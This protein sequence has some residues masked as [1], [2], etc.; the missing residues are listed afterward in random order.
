VDPHFEDICEHPSSDSFLVS[1]SFQEQYSTPDGASGNGEPHPNYLATGKA[2]TLTRTWS[3]SDSCLRSASQ[4]QIIYVT[5]TEAPTLRNIPEDVTSQCDEVPPPCIVTADDVCDKA[6]SVEYAQEIVPG[7]CDNRYTVYRTWTATDDS[8]NSVSHTQ[9]IEVV[10]NQAPEFIGAVGDPDSTVSVSCD[11][12]PIATAI[13][14]KDNCDESFNAVDVELDETLSGADDSS[15]NDYTIYRTWKATD[16][17]GNTATRTQTVHVSDTSPPEIE[18][19][20][21]DATYECDLVPPPCVA[22][23]TDNCDSGLFATMEA[24]TLTGTCEQEF[25]TIYT[26]TATD[27]SGNTASEAQTVY[28]QDTVAPHLVTTGIVDETL[29][30]SEI[31]TPTVTA[32]DDCGEVSVEYIESKISE[33]SDSEYTLRRSWT[34]TDDCGNT[35]NFVQTVKVV[36]TTPPTVTGKPCDADIGCHQDL[37]TANPV[38]TDDCCDATLTLTTDE[39]GRT[40]PFNYT[41]VRTWTAT[42]CAGNEETFQQHIVV[43]DDRGPILV[44]KP[45]DLFVSWGEEGE[46]ADVEVDHPCE[47]LDPDYTQSEITGTCHGEKTI[48]RTWSVTDSCGRTDSHTQ[49]ILVQDT[50]PPFILEPIPEDEEA[51]CLD[52]L[53]PPS[54]S[55]HDY[56][57]GPDMYATPATVT[58]E[59]SSTFQDPGTNCQYEISRTWTATDDCGNT[60]TT[61][62][63]VVV[64]DTS[65]PTFGTLDPMD[66]ICI[67]TD[68]SWQ[69][70]TVSD[71]CH[72]FTLSFVDTETPDTCSVLHSRKWTAVDD[73]GNEKSITDWVRAVYC[74]T[75]ELLNT[76]VNTT[77]ECGSP[78]PQPADVTS[79]LGGTPTYNQDVISTPG[80]HCEYTVLRTWT[81]SVPCYGT[82]QHVQEIVVSDNT[83]PTLVGVPDDEDQTCEYSPPVHNVD[84]TDDCSSTSVT[85]GYLYTPNDSPSDPQTHVFAWSATDQCGLTSEDVQTILVRDDEPP[86]FS[87]NY[88]QD[89]T[90]SCGDSTDD[91]T[92]CITPLQVSDN[93]GDNGLSLVF[94]DGSSGGTCLASSGSRTY[95]ATDAFG[96]TATGTVQWSITSDSGP[97]W[98]TVDGWE[99]E[100]FGECVAPYFQD[101][102]AQRDCTT[103][104]LDVTFS[105]EVVPDVNFLFKQK[106][107]WTAV[108]DCDRSIEKVQVVGAYDRSPPY[109]QSTPG[110]LT[111][112]AC[113]VVYTPPQLSWSDNCYDT[114]MTVDAEYSCTGSCPEICIATWSITDDAGLSNSHS[115]TVT[116]DD[117]SNPVLTYV[118]ETNS[119]LVSDCSAFTVIVEDFTNE[120]PCGRTDTYSIYTATDACSNSASEQTPTRTEYNVPTVTVENTPDDITSQCPVPAEDYA[121]TCSNGQ[122]PVLVSR[123]T[124]NNCPGLTNNTWTCTVTDGYDICHQD[125]YSQLIHVDDTIPPTIS[126]PADISCECG[127]EDDC[128]PGTATGEDNCDEEVDVDGS[129]VTVGWVTVA[130]WTATDTC[131]NTADAGSSTVTIIDTTPPVLNVIGDPD[132]TV[133]YPEEPVP[134]TVTCTD[135]CSATSMTPDTTESS[136]CPQH[137]A[138]T[139]TYS[140]V[141]ESGNQAVEVV[142]TTVVQDTTPPYFVGDLP[143]NTTVYWDEIPPKPELQA[144][145]TDDE[146]LSDSIVLS[147]QMIDI[148]SD[149]EYTLRRTWTVTDECGNVAVH[150]Q[151]ITVIPH[152]EY[153]F[154]VNTTVLCHSSIPP[155]ATITVGVNETVSYSSVFKPGSC[156]GQFEIHRTFVVLAADGYQQRA[157][158]TQ[159]VTVTDSAAPTWTSFPPDS[160]FE[161]DGSNDCVP[162]PPEPPTAED[163]CAFSTNPTIETSY[164]S[165]A[166]EMAALHPA[167][168]ASVSV[169]AVTGSPQTLND[170]VVYTWNA[171]DDCGNLLSSRSQTIHIHDTTA[172]AFDFP[173]G[174]TYNPSTTVPPSL[175]WTSDETL[176][177]CGELPEPTLEASDPCGDVTVTRTSQTNGYTCLNNYSL[178]FLF[179]A[180]DVNGNVALATKTY[181]VRDTTDPVFVSFPEDESAEC[182]LPVIVP[183]TAEDCGVSRSVGAPVIDHLVGENVNATIRTWT[184]H[185]ACGNSATQSQTITVTD[186][187]PPEILPTNLPEDVTEICVHNPAPDLEV[188][189]NCDVDPTVE[190]DE[191]VSSQTCESDYTIIR[192][193]TVSDEVDNQVTHTQTVTVQDPAPPSW[194]NPQP[195]PHVSASCMADLDLGLP[196]GQDECGT[197]TQTYSDAED[198]TCNG[199]AGAMVRTHTLDD[200]CHAPVTF[201]QSFSVPVPAGLLTHSPGVSV[202]FPDLSFSCPNDVTDAPEVTF[203][204]DCKEDRVVA[205]DETDTSSTNSCSYQIFRSWT[206]TDVCDVEYSEDQVVTV[207]HSYNPTLLVPAGGSVMCGM[208]TDPGEGSATDYCGN[209]LEVSKTVFVDNTGCQPVYTYTYTAVD[210]CGNTATE[211]VTVHVVDVEAPTLIGVPVDYTVTCDADVPELPTVADNCGS[212]TLTFSYEDIDEVCLHEFKRVYTWRAT[213][214]CGNAASRVTTI[215]VVNAG[216]PVWVNATLPLD[217]TSDGC[218]QLPDNSALLAVSACGDP[219]TAQPHRSTTGTVC[220]RTTVDTWTATDVCNDFITHSRTI[221]TADNTPPGLVIGDPMHLPCDNP[222]EPQ[223]PEVT[224]DCS[225]ATLTDKTSYVAPGS[226]GGVSTTVY[227]YEACNN[228]GACTTGQREVIRTDR[229]APTLGV[230][231]V[232]GT[233]ECKTEPSVPEPTADDNCD[234]DP[235]VSSAVVTTGANQNEV[236]TYTWTATDVCGNAVTDVTVMSAVDTQDP[237]FYGIPDDQSQYCSS[238]PAPP[239]TATDACEGDITV[240]TSST[241]VPGTC[242]QDYAI[243]RTFTASDQSGNTVSH[244]QTTSVYDTQAPVITL[245]PDLP[246][247]EEVECTLQISPVGSCTDCGACSVESSQVGNGELNALTTWSFTATDEC[248]NVASTSRSV[249]VYDRTPPSIADVVD[250][251]V[252]IEEPIPEDP[253][254]IAGDNCTTVTTTKSEQYEEGTC[255][256]NYYIIRTWTVVDGVGLTASTSQTIMVQDTQPPVI[257]LPSDLTGGVMEYSDVPAWW[258]TAGP[259]YLPALEGVTATD[260]SGFNIVVTVTADFVVNPDKPNEQVATFTYYAEDRCGNVSTEVAVFNVV[261]TT[262]CI[263][264]EVPASETVECDTVPGPCELR[265]EPGT[266]DGIPVPPA[267]VIE[268]DANTLVYVWTHVDPSGNTASASQTISI[269][270]TTP[271]IFTHLPQDQTVDCDCDSF[272]AAPSLKAL[273]NCFESVTTTFDESTSTHSNSNGY[274]LTRTWSASDGVNTVTHTQVITVEDND[275]PMISHLPSDSF[276]SCDAV[277][278]APTAFATDACDDDVDVQFTEIQS[279]LDGKSQSCAHRL[280]RVYSASDLDGN[281]AEKKYGIVVEDKT[282][283]V[284]A[285]GS[286]CVLPGEDKYFAFSMSGLFGATDA[287]SNGVTITVNNCTSTQSHSDAGPSP[288]SADCRLEDGQ[289][290][291]KAEVTGANDRVYSVHATLED[292]CGNR[293]FV[294]KDIKVPVNTPAPSEACEV[295]F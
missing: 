100:R 104:G 31:Y 173:S 233:Y 67:G 249:Y 231:P 98:V 15:P 292:D 291:V 161:L 19:I 56:T 250:H 234:E 29:E 82:D 12:V 197:P 226:C 191:T 269:Q 187:T 2:Y 228:C 188:S 28:V 147:S 137:V 190:L 209:T 126:P 282:A 6:V 277:P 176:E 91:A 243:V 136:D 10:D 58:L 259:D 144:F 105:D 103:R 23:V 284:M 99:D 111:L 68:P 202:S 151:Y 267:S 81:V 30:C 63:V 109:F 5:D 26:W 107:T 237:I 22:E 280:E 252:E 108:D 258:A 264:L 106:R 27:T 157:S 286:K 221:V 232:D 14:A 272:P 122:P 164:T 225:V 289:V 227:V 40:C 48:L 194:A 263:L 97:E 93:C 76:P 3:G 17:C 84:A 33:I 165:A 64:R 62:Q 83:P 223:D 42:D 69:T 115:Q 294:V 196:S 254:I 268:L 215:T 169:N 90:C 238:N 112:D 8:N 283:P 230:V 236:I 32:N 287:C 160:T 200:G 13:S 244:A 180:I 150:I 124:G 37:P 168:T 220:S 57:Y 281:P 121:V 211:D 175:R 79:T 140:C 213:D 78:L 241:T 94:S 212:A 253:E 61:S 148:V 273:D 210:A 47:S 132:V 1:A 217:D 260:N 4:S 274:T 7:G 96:H 46:P 279:P 51:D 199:N 158:H 16:D 159:T 66:D 116:I 131:G 186:V 38:A 229:E 216:D 114:W 36:D 240:V 86:V 201:V 290:R 146:D 174:W 70:P 34:A 145:N 203:S 242:P 261:D 45:G 275:P 52:D 177:A 128:T 71:D 162:P 156:P 92:N 207:G 60:N 138:T 25:T 72:G 118:N 239:P 278:A 155:P 119:Y 80:D 141:D 251:T 179:Q 182:D 246:E 43:S 9:T 245:S 133:E 271:P 208:D 24:T 170:K 198:W 293:R 21:A 41:V 95:T 172:P 75:V 257:T 102:E 183:P 154:P 101:L 55:A 218:P 247:Y 35:D 134:P 184:V 117:S 65:S 125:H 123:S 54:V 49:T 85:S 276:A 171:A 77:S 178:I 266:G 149:Q 256:D 288:F 110:D 11:A 214:T 139:T 248:G 152:Y 88:N 59:E 18:N 113:D 193:W 120:L 222:A 262:K 50:T 204:E 219:L 224:E 235:T 44:N 255:E 205:V 285:P 87:G 167:S 20:D 195:A 89:F 163:L 295:P 127:K 142:T 53:S 73:C 192:T 265:C 206:A 181:H 135:T 130:T 74:E 153:E 143:Q 166:D 185:D 189:D 129:F 270:D 39:L